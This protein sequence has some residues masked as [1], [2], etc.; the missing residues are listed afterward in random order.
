MRKWMSLLGLI[1]L[2]TI[3]CSPSLPTDKFV[4]NHLT[5]I[6]AHDGEFDLEVVGNGNSITVVRGEI[7]RLYI[8]GNDHEITV[9]LGVDVR[10]INLYGNSVTVRLP[11]D[12]TPEIS[13]SGN[14]CKVIVD[15]VAD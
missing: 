2:T 11:F 4:G 6:V 7:R 3:G 13:K 8:R 14:N 10:S 15:L 12:V 1:L 5:G 9:R